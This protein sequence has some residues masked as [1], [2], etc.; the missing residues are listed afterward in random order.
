M[1]KNHLISS[2]IFVFSSI[3]FIN[4]VTANVIDTAKPLK[5]QKLSNNKSHLVVKT[6]T[7]K[8]PLKTASVPAAPAEISQ[9]SRLAQ[10]APVPSSFS[11]EISVG[12][13]IAAKDNDQG[14]KDQWML[15]SISPAW[16]ISDRLSLSGSFSVDQTI[17][18]EK[19]TV[20]SEGLVPLTYKGWFF[21]PK[22]YTRHM[23]VALLPVNP[24]VREQNRDQGGIR[25]GNGL[26]T[27]YEIFSTSYTFSVQRNF[28]DLSGFE[29]EIRETKKNELVQWALRHRIDGGIAFTEAFSL[30]LALIYIEGFSYDQERPKSFMTKTLFSYEFLDSLAAS[31]G[32]MNEADALKEN[33]NSNIRLFDD[34]TS[35]FTAAISYGF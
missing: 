20:F 8:S 35:A 22:T 26:V 21:T 34:R 11:T 2:F 32:F 4:I 13:N 16:R 27:S 17:N 24:V 9:K 19:K 15:Y 23:L 18:G 12:W 28:H 30:N 7:K 29:P 1:H 14:F 25:V 3:M 31:V 6:S 10:T 5:R 33:K